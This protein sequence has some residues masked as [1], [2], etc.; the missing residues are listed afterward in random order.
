MARR[1]RREYSPISGTTLKGAEP[2][3]AAHLS[4]EVPSGSLGENAAAPSH[5]PETTR[6]V[7]AG[8]VAIPVQP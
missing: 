5:D 8:S 7:G 3:R 4:T 6:Y 1:G 2:A